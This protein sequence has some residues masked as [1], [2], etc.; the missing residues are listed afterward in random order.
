MNGFIQKPSLATHLI[1][2]VS[3]ALVGRNVANQ[4]A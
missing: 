2:Q 3:R 1:D 4:R